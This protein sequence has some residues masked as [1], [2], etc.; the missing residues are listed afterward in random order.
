[1]GAV[2]AHVVDARS[3]PSRPRTTKT[4]SPA[5]LTVAYWFGSA[6]WLRCITQIQLRAKMVFFSCSKMSCE[7]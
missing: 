5:T 6:T 3:T 2:R 7:V 4:F 1:M